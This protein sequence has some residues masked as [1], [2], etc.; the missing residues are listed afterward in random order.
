M[1]SLLAKRL[2]NCNILSSFSSKL[3]PFIS[4][5]VTIAPAF[6]IGFEGFFVS[7]VSNFIIELNGSPLGSIPTLENT[8]VQSLSIKAIAKT[9]G[10]DILCIVNLVL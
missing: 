1:L 2:K 5:V 6:I 4:E 10:L 7:F 9:I 8:V 3:L